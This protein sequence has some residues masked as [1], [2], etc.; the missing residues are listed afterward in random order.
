MTQSEVE[1]KNSKLSTCY[2]TSDVT[3]GEIISF[4][5][6]TAN[7]DTNGGIHINSRHILTSQYDMHSV[8]T[9]ISE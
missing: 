4:Y 5:R 2:P 7:I 1:I 9:D 8:I 3:R 6:I